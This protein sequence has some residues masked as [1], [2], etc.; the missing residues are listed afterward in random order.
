MMGMAT[1]LRAYARNFEYDPLKTDLE[2]NR[3]HWLMESDPDIGAVYFLMKDAAAVIDSLS[4]QLVDAE[5]YASIL[6]NDREELKS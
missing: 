6:H 1:K 5:L 3:L 4:K 2:Q